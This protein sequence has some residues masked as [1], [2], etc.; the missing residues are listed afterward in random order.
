MTSDVPPPPPPA[1][2]GWTKAPAP[3]DGVSIAAL[4][5]SLICCTAP[6]GIVLGFFGILRTGEGLRRGRWAAVTGLVVGVALSLVMGLAALVGV[7]LVVKSTE[8]DLDPADASPGMCLDL[9]WADDANATSCE[10]K[11]EGEVIWVGV[12][13]RALMREWDDAE[14]VDDFCYARDIAEAYRETASD[15]RFE[16]DYYADTFSGAPK[17]G[18][19]MICYV[20]AAEGKLTGPV[21]DPRPTI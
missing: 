11:H 14:Y 8:N 19:W 13:T 1:A 5:C 17:A 2:A 9:D 4:V 20:E 16:V 18:S 21:A 15:P 10:G 7:V 12:M 6:V 3:Y